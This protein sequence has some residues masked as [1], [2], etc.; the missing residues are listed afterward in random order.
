[1]GGDWTRRQVLGRAGA[2]VAGAAG[3]GLAG[4]AGTSVSRRPR[5]A[6]L[7]GNAGIQSFVSRPD[8]SPPDITAS[9]PDRGDG[10]FVFLGLSEAGRGQGGNAILDG[11]GDL[12][13]FSPNAT[14]R[15]KM[16]LMAQTYRG[17]P[18]LTWWEGKVNA[19]G[20][21]AGAAVIADSSYGVIK[22][23]QAARG[24][25]AD[26]HEF[27]L[28]PQGTAL[29]T[30][31][32]QAEA[33]LTAFGG[34]ARGQVLSG[35][36]QE[37]EVASG[38][39]LF[40]WDSLHHVALSETYQKFAGGTPD[41]P[42]NYFHINSIAVAPDGDLI[43]SARNTWA[44]YK[45]A[46]PS[47]AIRW[48][49]G[50]KKSSFARGKGTHFYWQHDA[51]PHGA[52]T[53]SLFDDGASPKEEPRS[54]ALLLDL[55]TTR[56]RA[57]LRRQYVHPDPRLL[58]WAMGN[59]QM[60]PGGRVFVGWGTD[61]YYSEFSADGRLLL[62]GRLA[63]GSWSY[64]AFSFPWS[65]HPAQRPAVA[66]RSRPGGGTTV[67]A[68]WNGATDV[69][70]WTVLAGTSASSLSEVGSGRRTG[71]ETAIAVH[72]AGPHFAVEPRDARGRVMARSAAVRV[73]VG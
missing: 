61:P 65:G 71:F 15:H 13:W 3:L 30:V 9:G 40:E 18:V 58:A 12:V 10:R 31:N 51:R 66:A 73:N 36:V 72:H 32:R 41:N 4:C 47:G 16:N 8:L 24:L 14:A 11:R 60:L 39:L 2:A 38:K 48:R 19:H 43:V 29:I 54:R 35:G 22:T 50:G 55:D 20:Y 7:T 42:F 70:A 45:I 25:S 6:G 34:P 53:L 26:V 62:D 59:V 21:G 63:K 57:T 56:M 44:V 68:S 33:D 52:S 64:R 37:I 67:Y 5:H 28:T 27:L 1:M 17:R 69:H 49:L 46:R 23:V